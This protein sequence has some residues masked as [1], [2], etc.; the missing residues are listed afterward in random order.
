M[1]DCTKCGSPVIPGARFCNKC[2]AAMPAQP[3]QPDVQARSNSPV[4]CTRCGRPIPEGATF[5]G[6]CGTPALERVAYEHK[7]GLFRRAEEIKRKNGARVLISSLLIVFFGLIVL[8]LLLVV[9]ANTFLDDLESFVNGILPNVLLVLLPLVLLLILLIWG[10]SRSGAFRKAG[11]TYDQYSRI[12]ADR[13]LLPKEF[14]EMLPVAIPW[15]GCP[16]P[17]AAIPKK[18]SSPR[19]LAIIMSS[20]ILLCISV[21][22]V[23]YGLGGI[24]LSTSGDGGYGGLGSMQDDYLDGKVYAAQGSSSGGMTT[25]GAALYFEDGTVYFGTEGMSAAE[26]KDSSSLFSPMDVTYSI[27]GTTIYLTG[28]GSS[29]QYHYDA[30]SDSIRAG[31]SVYYRID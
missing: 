30:A 25:M 4:R 1:A 3:V 16:P 24:D 17:Q 9:S 18:A 8:T 5:C 20:L 31:S 10:V 2:G 28:G 22:A 6:T 19:A 26:I 15:T 21:L 27:E 13:K 23:W 7:V 12:L 29:N 11:L 14:F